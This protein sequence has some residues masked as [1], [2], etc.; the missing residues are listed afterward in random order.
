MMECGA[1]H[2]SRRCAIARLLR[3]RS[4]LERVDRQRSEHHR[5]NDGECAIEGD[6]V[7]TMSRPPRKGTRVQVQAGFRRWFAH[8]R[9]PTPH[10]TQWNTDCAGIQ[11]DLGNSDMNALTDSYCSQKFSAANLSENFIRSDL[12]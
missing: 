11:G 8:S 6:R 7:Q 9:S 3:M 2:P 10:C 12:S 1:A 5:G 4:F